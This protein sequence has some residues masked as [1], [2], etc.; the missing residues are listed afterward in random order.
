MENNNTIHRGVELQENL[1]MVISRHNGLFQ[2]EQDISRVIDT[3]NEVAGNDPNLGF[4]SKIS[5]T[6]TI[7]GNVMVLDLHLPLMRSTRRSA[8]E[9]GFNQRVANALMRNYGALNVGYVNRYGTR[10][11]EVETNLSD[12]ELLDH[13]P[14]GTRIV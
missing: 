11:V 5:G 4:Y 6:G 9:A 2:S 14:Q 13:L 1:K 3:L 10:R 12:M 8:N 7:F